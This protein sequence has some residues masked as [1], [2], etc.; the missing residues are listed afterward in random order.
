[1]VETDVKT[2]IK[3]VIKVDLSADE[4]ALILQHARFV[5]SDHD[6]QGDLDN[7]RKKWVRFVPDELTA[8][9]GELTYRFNRTEDDYQFY[10]LDQL[11]DHMEYYQK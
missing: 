10:M 11:I 9:I 1:M 8:V 3:T 5:L 4:K 7:K 2:V 6:T